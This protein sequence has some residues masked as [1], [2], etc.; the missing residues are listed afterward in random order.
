[1]PD[2]GMSKSV[3][4]ASVPMASNFGGGR[5]GPITSAPSPIRQTPN[6]ES[7]RTER[8]ASSM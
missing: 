6:G 1:M 2:S 4:R 5:P 7:S 3:I 8:L